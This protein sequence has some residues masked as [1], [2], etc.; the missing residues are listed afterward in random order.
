MISNNDDVLKAKLLD[1]RF[2]LE[3]YNQYIIR[4]DVEIKSLEK[5]L[6]KNEEIKKILTYNVNKIKLNE[7]LKALLLYGT[8]VTLGGLM[9]DA[10]SNTPLIHAI[11]GMLL[12]SVPA[13]II[14]I[15]SLQMSYAKVNSICNTYSTNDVNKKIEQAKNDLYFYKSLL[16]DFEKSK[17]CAQTKITN[18]VN[19]I[20]I[21][22]KS[23]DSKKCLKVSNYLDKNRN[24]EEIIVYFDDELIAEKTLVLK[25]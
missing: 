21:E 18:I 6:L 1:S 19:E 9:F 24:R 8:I 12:T 17:D 16:T 20:N 14:P 10:G 5:E 23:S 3:H 4:T 11:D 15:I 2:E 13:L 22:K 25:K 7:F